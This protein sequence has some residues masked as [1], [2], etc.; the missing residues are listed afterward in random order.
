MIHCAPVLRTGVTLG[1]LAYHQ[2][3]SLRHSFPTQK[4]ITY[5]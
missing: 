5:V 1:Y 3:A 4:I 2:S